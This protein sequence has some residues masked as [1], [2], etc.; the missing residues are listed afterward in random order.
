MCLATLMA[1]LDTSLVNLDLKSIQHDLR[2]HGGTPVG[3]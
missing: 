2:A 3:H 1:I